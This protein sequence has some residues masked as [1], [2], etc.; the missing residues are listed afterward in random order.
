MIEHRPYVPGVSHLLN[1]ALATKQF[2]SERKI[3]V[4]ITYGFSC[5]LA[6]TQSAHAQYERTHMGTHTFITGAKLVVTSA[7]IEHRPYVP[8]VSHLLNMALATK[9]HRSERK[10]FK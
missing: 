10:T 2:R 1:M 8:G 7:M 9:Q 3:P 5:L 6:C 4:Q